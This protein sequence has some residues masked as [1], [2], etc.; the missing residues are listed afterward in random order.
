M[1]QD[2]TEVVV[3]VSFLLLLLFCFVF[4]AI[5][6][7]HIHFHCLCSTA[8]NCSFQQNGQEMG[9]RSGQALAGPRTSSGDV[10]AKL[11]KW[12]CKTPFVHVQWTRGDRLERGSV[13]G[14][15]VMTGPNRDG[16]PFAARGLA[17]YP[18][19]SSGRCEGGQRS[20]GE[21][22]GVGMGLRRVQ[23][24]GQMAGMPGSVS[25]PAQGSNLS[26]I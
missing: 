19:G 7:F 14:G 4:L 16:H 9:C 6:P 26:E 11:N 3:K 17:P 21:R 12:T 10:R 1:E 13:T 20:R 5:V 2:P 8:I 15:E 22:G 25:P 18:L 24:G 23:R